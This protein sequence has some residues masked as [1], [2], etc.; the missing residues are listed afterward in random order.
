MLQGPSTFASDKFFMLTLI[1]NSTH[2]AF[3]QNLE[4]LGVSAMPRPLTDCFNNFEGVLFEHVYSVRGAYQCVYA[5][6]MQT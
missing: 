3:Y 5:Q 1:V 6:Y 4:L 2:A